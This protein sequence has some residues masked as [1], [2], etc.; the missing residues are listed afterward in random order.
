[1]PH[2]PAAKAEGR[3]KTSLLDRVKRGEVL[4]LVEVV[5][6]RPTLSDEPRK[7][8]SRERMASSMP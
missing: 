6:H 2:I 1:L 4:G 3:L 8:P 7:T 5:K